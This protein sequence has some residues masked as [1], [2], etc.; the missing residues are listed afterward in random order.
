MGARPGP[1][2]ADFPDFNAREPWG[3]E[4]LVVE[5]TVNIHAPKRY[6]HSGGG[7]PEGSAIY[8]LF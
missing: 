2:D 7:G 8:L 5:E 6:A 3:D 1:R 4:K